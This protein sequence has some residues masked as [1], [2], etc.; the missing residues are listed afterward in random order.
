[1]DNIKYIPIFFLLLIPF[2]F[3]WF[4][5]FRFL[6][7][8]IT[9]FLHY[10]VLTLFSLIA[11]TCYFL[12]IGAIGFSGI[13]GNIGSLI[14][15]ISYVIVIYTSLIIVP[16]IFVTIIATIVYFTNKPNKKQADT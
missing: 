15:G 4:F 14:G 12:L 2:G 1:M 9:T 10:C 5:T 16:A 13:E 11:L 6:K 8:Y 7:Q 3:I